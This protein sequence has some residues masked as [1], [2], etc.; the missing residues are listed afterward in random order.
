[1][2]SIKEIETRMKGMQDI[3]HL[4]RSVRAMSAIRWRK[5]KKHLEM[6]Q[7]YAKLDDG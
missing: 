4:L 7:E 5:A 2:H 6:A 3:K 1:M